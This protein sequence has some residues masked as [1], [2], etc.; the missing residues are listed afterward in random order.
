MIELPYGRDVLE[1]DI[2]ED[3]DAAGQP[4]TGLPGGCAVLRS[5]IG[6]LVAEEPGIDIVR[7]AMASPIGS[8]RLAELAKGKKSC[9]II[10]SDHTRPVPSK[11]LIPPMLEELREGQPDSDISLL[12]GYPRRVREIDEKIVAEVIKDMV[13]VA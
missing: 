13:G 3:K 6:E 7:R 12:V 1:L 8:P 5:R 2:R 10:I 11:D 4:V 9:T